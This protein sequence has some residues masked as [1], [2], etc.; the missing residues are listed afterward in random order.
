MRID[1]RGASDGPEG[2]DAAAAMQQGGTAAAGEMGEWMAKLQSFN[3]TEILLFFVIYFFGGY[4][5]YASLFAAIGSVIDHPDDSQQFMT[6]VIMILAFALYA[7]IYSIENPDGP[8]A[9]WC[10][11]IPFTSPVVM[12]M[13]IPYETP[14]WQMLLSVS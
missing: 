7:G 11:M 4:L 13:R 12:M 1:V 8:L 3:F 2:A 14:L 9:F 6:P 10:S 5:L